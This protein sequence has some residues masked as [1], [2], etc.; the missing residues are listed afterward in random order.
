MMSFMG[1]IGSMMKGSGLEEALETVY[2]S[3]AVNHIIS[4][5]AVSRALR[6]HFLIEAAL[7]NKLIHAIL[8]LTEQ[9]VQTSTLDQDSVNPGQGMETE[10]TMEYAPEHTEEV[11]ALD[12]DRQVNV[13]KYKVI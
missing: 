1:S 12:H 9:D 11:S 2:G 5:K 7:V 3:N 13:M 6:G 4:G 8:P 10:C